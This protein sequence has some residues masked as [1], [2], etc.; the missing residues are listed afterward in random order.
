[1]S[2]SAT[3][4]SPA[5]VFTSSLMLC[6]L[7]MSLVLNPTANQGVA[8]A[9]QL[10]FPLARKG[11][12]EDH[13]QELR[14]CSQGTTDPAPPSLPGF[15]AFHASLKEFRHD[16]VERLPTATFPN[17]EGFREDLSTFRRDLTE[18]LP[19]VPRFKSKSANSLVPALHPGKS[20]GTRWAAFGQE[21]SF[22][23]HMLADKSARLRISGLINSDDLISY[24]YNALEDGS[25]ALAFKVPASLTAKTDRVMTKLKSASIDPQGFPVIVVRPPIPFDV[26]LKLKPTN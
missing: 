6:G 3:L 16:M 12:F 10:S 19:M 26:R 9:T 14:K 8:N 2:E 23:L 17:L 11:A 5:S 1:M 24:E 15:E 18:R 20:Y 7:L 21:L 25:V 13:Q 4:F 22:E